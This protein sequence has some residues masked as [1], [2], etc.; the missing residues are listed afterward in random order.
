MVGSQAHGSGPGGAR[1]GVGGRARR[2]VL[3]E[4]GEAGLLWLHV[5]AGHSALRSTA[6]C[7]VAAGTFEEWHSGNWKRTADVRL[8]T[9]AGAQ[10]VVYG[11]SIFSFDGGSVPRLMQRL[12]LPLAPVPSPVSD[13]KDSSCDFCCFLCPR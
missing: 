3:F 2:L 5:P 13:T 4:R 1:G 10:R 9:R 6:A 8:R 11:R 12:D 7:D